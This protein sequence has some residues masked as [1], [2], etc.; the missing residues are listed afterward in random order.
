METF[1][2][3]TFIT[4]IN[5]Y[6]RY[7]MFSHIFCCIYDNSSAFRLFNIIIL[8]FL[9]LLLFLSFQEIIRIQNIFKIEFYISLESH[10]I[11]NLELLRTNQISGYYVQRNIYWLNIV[12]T[13]WHP[14]I[15]CFVVVLRKTTFI[16]VQ[17]IF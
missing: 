7:Y 5:Y 12:Q 15:S 3:S 9:H 11:A 13:D 14:L 4:F 17:G 6:K 2:K 8:L 10:Y 16:F 1:I